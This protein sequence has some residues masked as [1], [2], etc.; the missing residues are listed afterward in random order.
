[1]ASCPLWTLTGATTT[2]GATLGRNLPLSA[3]TLI[4]KSRN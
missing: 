1:M 3:V 4:E 2:D